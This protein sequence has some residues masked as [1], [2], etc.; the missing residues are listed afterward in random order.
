[1][2]N[3]EK[4]IVALT[5]LVLF[6]RALPSF[7]PEVKMESTRLTLMLLSISYL[8]GGYW[9]FR[10]NTKK[11]KVLSVIAG[12]ALCPSVYYLHLLLEVKLY[13]NIECFLLP[14]QLLFVV[15]GVVLLFKR[16]TLTEKK[17]IRGIFI[18]SV[19]VAVFTAFLYFIP[20]TSAISRNVLS[21]FNGGNRSLQNNLKMAEY[22][23]KSKTAYIKGDCESALQYA[24]AANKY[25]KL[26][27]GID[28]NAKN[29]P[30]D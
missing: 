20:A 17:S 26:W 29:I 1:L 2:R 22:Y 6:S 21:F 12:I 24:V 25:G 27:L 15:L 13:E 3:Y 16:K 5:L 18:R 14:N 10:K 19:T 28:T 9:L 23:G 7:D 11:L 30:I 8:V 4:I